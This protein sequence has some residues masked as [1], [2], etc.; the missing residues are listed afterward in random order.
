[1]SSSTNN[2]T[3]NCTTLAVSTL[4]KPEFSSEWHAMKTYISGVASTASDDKHP[5]QQQA[6]TALAGLP[7]PAFFNACAVTTKRVHKIHALLA[8]IR[9][10]F[11]ATHGYDILAGDEANDDTKRKIFKMAE[12]QAPLVVAFEQE[13]QKKRKAEKTPAKSPKKAKTTATED[14]DVAAI[15]MSAAL[16]QTMPAALTQKTTEKTTE[17]TTKEDE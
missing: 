9:Q 15:P 16:A 14:G 6:R 5:F 1:M 3:A 11:L 7:E 12:E 17:E 4:P 8:Q 2:E 13:A 10:D